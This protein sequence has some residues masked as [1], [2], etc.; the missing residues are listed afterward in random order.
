MTDVKVTLSDKRQ[1]ELQKITNQD[2]GEFTFNKQEVECGDDYVYVRAQKEDYSVAENKVDIIKSGDNIRTELFLQRIRKQ[3]TVGDNLAKFFNIEIIY[4]D[5]DKSN[6]RYDAAVDLS[7]I[8]EV[9]KEY[10][11]MKIAIKSHTDSRGSDAYNLALSD[12][13]A[14]STLEWMVKQGISRDRLTAKGYGETQLVNGC[15]NGVPCTE[16][17]HQAN[18]RSEFIITEM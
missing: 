9:M 18:R 1:N 8:V 4:F 10:P 5:F 6:I 11:K 7:K 15:S 13:R 3:F 14:K 12:R 2:N 17:E 16:E